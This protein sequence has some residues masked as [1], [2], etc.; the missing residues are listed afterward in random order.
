MWKICYISNMSFFRFIPLPSLPPFPS[1]I[2]MHTPPNWE[3]VNSKRHRFSMFTIFLEQ[4]FAHSKCL[5]NFC[6]KCLCSMICCFRYIY[7]SQILRSKRYPIGYFIN[8]LLVC[9][10]LPFSQIYKG[11]QQVPH[12]A[13]LTSHLH[14]S[15]SI[16][17]LLCSP[18]SLRSFRLG[19][20]VIGIGWK[21][22]LFCPVNKWYTYKKM[23]THN[24]AETQA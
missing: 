18:L 19:C 1:H 15:P 8:Y 4:C 21:R 17:V 13:L 7:S 9:I 16:M 11:K 20:H 12:D 2:H 23:P 10:L 5:M 22:C 3:N 24:L 14:Q 6:W